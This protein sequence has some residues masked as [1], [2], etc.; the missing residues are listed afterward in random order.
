MSSSPQIVSDE[1][2]NGSLDQIDVLCDA[3]EEAH[4]RGQQ[5]RIR[6]YLERCDTAQRA[7]AFAELMLVELELSQ[8]STAGASY[9]PYLALFPE[10]ADVIESIAFKHG[11]IA[12]HAG[13]GRDTTVAGAAAGEGEVS[14]A[15]APAG[16]SQ[17]AHFQ[18]EEK[19]GAGGMGEVWRAWDSRLKRTVAIKIPRNCNLDERGL[20]RF[21]HEGRAV[22]RLKHPHIV[23]VYEVGRDGRLAYIVSDYIAGQSLQ[24]RL[25]GQIV[26]PLQA[27]E[28]CRQLAEALHHAHQQGVIHRDLKPANVLL[29]ADGAPH[30]VDFGIA[31]WMDDAQQATL[32]GHAVGTPAYMS[33]EQARGDSAHVD[34]RADVYA[35]GAVLY[36]MLTGKL[37]IEA[38][39][40]EAL[41]RAVV[42]EVPAP[43]RSIR[44]EIPRD[45]ETICLKAIEKEPARRYSTAAEMAADLGRFM[46][47]DPILGRR[48]GLLEK[49]ARVVRRRPAATVAA[50]LALLACSALGFAAVLARENHV[51]QGLVP[52]QLETNPPGARVVFVPLDETTQEPRGDASVNPRGRSPV[53]AEL[54]PG[55]YL[56]IAALDDGRF[57][58]VYRHVPKDPHQQAHDSTRRS[59][60]YNAEH[61]VVLQTIDIPEL[62]VTDGMAR[63]EPGVA[64]DQS[65]AGG[66]PRAA[67]FY[68]DVREATYRDCLKASSSEFKSI[69]E[70]GK[71]DHAAKL[72]FNRACFYAEKLGKRLPTAAEFQR[73][74]AQSRMASCSL[75]ESS[76]TDFGPAG[77][78]EC[79][80][81]G[82]TLPIAGL[83]SNVAEWT[84]TVVRAA[85]QGASLQG[86]NMPHL[87]NFRLVKGGDMTVIEGNPT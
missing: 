84:T 87:A 42:D 77:A 34:L 73:A 11:L 35:L 65:D 47:G 45:L 15:N 60:K 27:A 43:P 61:G 31:K 57:H 71:L 55:D 24:Q 80:R 9:R 5:P 22:A 85:E 20:E 74:A 81:V 40:P 10:Y 16:I 78:P 66:F 69:E 25:D 53:N 79:D 59:W 4:R 2:S 28:L 36:R 67:A 7:A 62:S 1:T 6:E 38:A 70:S 50:I 39:T 33:P 23:P 46:R 29:S 54:K 14:P 72:D 64:S 21:L 41:M 51:L 18:L 12:T 52:V 75:S 56:V 13:P 26:Q 3:F 19:L 68:V 17:I 86:L 76:E 83:Y 48:P 49:T 58:E 32:D 8:G 30:V 37:P 44:R 63:V 82:N